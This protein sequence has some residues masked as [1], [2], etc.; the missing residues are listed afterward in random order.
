MELLMSMWNALIWALFG[1]VLMFLGYKI[2]DWLTP[3]N[4]NDK[5]DEGNVAAGVAAAGIF[6]A[7]AWIV[8]AAIA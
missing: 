6:L 7:V 5:I 4:L 8:S 1:M 2:F 3:F